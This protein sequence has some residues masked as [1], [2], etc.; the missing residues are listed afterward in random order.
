MGKFIS[1]AAFAFITFT[2]S[3]A[4][5][6]VP[7]RSTTAIEHNNH[8]KMADDWI[9]IRQN[10]RG[11]G[12]QRGGGRG[13][14]LGRP[15]QPRHRPSGAQLTNRQHHL[16]PAR[17]TLNRRQPPQH[18]SRGIN[19]STTLR[20][21][22]HHRGPGPRKTC[23]MR[24]YFQIHNTAETLRVETYKN[25]KPQHSPEPSLP[26]DFDIPPHYLNQLKRASHK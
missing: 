26:S 12:N 11:R 19:S 21:S 8:N 3:F 5:A 13:G 10:N 16:R 18:L 17:S 6:T 22:P 9:P 15:P 2:S 1:L 23:W 25:T 7:V 20:I 24:I 14:R 4:Y